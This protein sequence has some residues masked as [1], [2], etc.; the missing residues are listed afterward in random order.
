MPS[1]Q[2]A[3][4]HADEVSGIRRDGALDGL[5]AVA[6]LSVVAFH[7]WLY[8][9]SDPTRPTRE[10]FSN[11]LLFEGRIGLVLFF[12]LSGFLLFRPFMRG[13]ISLRRYFARRAARIVPAYWVALVGA[14]LLLWGGGGTPG[15]RLPDAS[16]LGLFAVFGQNYSDATIMQLNPVTWTLCVE[17]AF[18]LLLPLLRPR[19]LPLLVVVGLGWNLFVHVSAAGQIAGKAL[20]A[21][22]PYF[23]VG[24][25]GAVWPMRRRVSPFSIAGGVSGGGHG[26]GDPPGGPRGGKPTP[27]RGGGFSAGGGVV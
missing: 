11:R 19:L 12:V 20:P 8:T 24:M 21:F 23:A 27:P 9:A 25:A 14:V 4:C 3:R 18:Y 6:A 15:I 1:T 5:R 26:G 7:V 13:G 16:S 10:G 2:S 22:L 17:V